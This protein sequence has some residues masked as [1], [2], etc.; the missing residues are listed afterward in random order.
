MADRFV[1][2]NSVAMAWCFDDESDSYSREVLY[3]LQNAEAFVPAIWP[4]EFGNALL[5]A[6]RNKPPKHYVRASRVCMLLLACV[7]IVVGT[8]LSGILDAYKYIGVITGGVSLVMILRWYW[9]RVNPWSEISAMTASLVLGNLA[10]IYLAN[11]TDEAGV[12]HDLFALRLVLVLAAAT[13]VWLATTFLTSTSPKTTV[14]AFHRKMRIGG[15]GWRRIAE[16]ENPEGDA[17]RRD[18]SLGLTT[19]AWLSAV[20]CLYAA[21]LGVGKLLFHEWGAALFLLAILAVSGVMLHRCIRKM[22]MEAG[23]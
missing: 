6:E 1:L 3:S 15:P 5:V 19:A 17:R 13:V 4:L 9:W 7:A 23:E 14:R 21:L 2:D 18:P 11:Y 16:E 10:E 8:R 12:V 22:A 20:C